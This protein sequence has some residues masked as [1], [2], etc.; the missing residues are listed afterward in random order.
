MNGRMKEGRPVSAGCTL[1]PSSWK[2]EHIDK[3]VDGPDGI[4]LADPFVEK[5]PAGSPLSPVHFYERGTDRINIERM[6]LVL[7]LADL[8]IVL[9]T[10]PHMLLVND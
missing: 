10:V 5:F 6:E 2:I 8:F 3:R 7:P 9:R 1:K 4:V